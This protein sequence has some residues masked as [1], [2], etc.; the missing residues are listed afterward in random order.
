MGYWPHTEDDTRQMLDR[1]GTG[2]VE[3]LFADIPEELRQSADLELPPGLSEMEVEARLQRLADLN[4]SSD[5]T[6]SFLGAGCYD[7]YVPAVVSSLC[8][9]SEFV[10]SYTPYQPEA[11]QGTLQ[12]IYEFQSL[13]CDLTG[14][15]VANASLY[16]GASALAEAA[17]V[18]L[19]VSD[20][21]RILVPESVHP[22]YRA[23]LDT[24]THRSHIELE[25]VRC[26]SGVID[27][28]HLSDLAQAPFAAA[29]VQNPNFFGCLEECE[30]VSR[31]V[32]ERGGRLISVFDPISLALVETPGEYDA[33]L[34]VAEGQALGIGQSLG[35]PGLG[36][37]TAKQDLLRRLPGRLVG[38][39]T[40]VNGKPGYVLTL[41]TREQHIRREKA[42]SNICTNQGL[43]ALAA[44]VYLCALGPRGVRAVAELCLQKA[45]YTRRRLAELAGIELPF[46][47]PFFKEFTVSCPAPAHQV[48]G[49]LREAGLLGG[50]PLR[51]DFDWLPNGLLLCV[52]EK[53]RRHELDA[54]VSVLAEL[55][56]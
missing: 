10:T 48:N 28:N 15:D 35:G 1:L 53:R 51:R 45:H 13:L 25:P 27:L 9:R 19:S 17:F 54:L 3:D 22:A 41:Q 47:A 42:T 46:S 44:T 30:V 8:T 18:A 20:S 26:R 33:D 39:T 55:C 43:C 50:Y 40:D 11:S 36:I 31:L 24:Y 7:H 4:L 6:P 21:P 5:R 12:V 2:S 29:V 37:M 34:A 23:V 52:T 56:T 38:A 14:M 32:H 49:R 16:D